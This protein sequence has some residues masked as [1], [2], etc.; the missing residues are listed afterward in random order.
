[1]S[2]A[3]SQPRATACNHPTRRAADE[4]HGALTR[5]GDLRE[6]EGRN[7]DEANEPHGLGGRQARSQRRAIQRLDPRSL[8]HTVIPHC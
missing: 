2:E 4:P 5:Q 1:M 7:G 6:A 3:T 8:L